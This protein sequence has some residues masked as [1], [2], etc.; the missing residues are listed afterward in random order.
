M[1]AGGGQQRQA[2][3]VRFVLRH[4]QPTLYHSKRA[5]NL[6]S[7]EV[8]FDAVDLKRNMSLWEERTARGARQDALHLGHE[9]QSAAFCR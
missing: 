5:G 8:A 1:T 4:R 2:L 7:R 3:G 9:L 6:E